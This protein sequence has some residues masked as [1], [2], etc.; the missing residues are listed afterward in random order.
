[1]TDRNETSAQSTSVD[2]RRAS[3]TVHWV[4][5]GRSTGSGLAALA[6]VADVVLWGRADD[7]IENCL[8]RNG[9]R[10][11]V[12]G[13]RYDPATLAAALVPGDVLV[14]MVPA[15]EHPELLRACLER[16]AHFAC[17]SYTSPQ[18]QALEPAAQKAGIVV[19]TEAGLDPGIDHLLAH[20]LVD[21]ARR[22]LGDTPAV[23]RLTSYCGGLPAEPNE[24][25]YRFSWAPTGVLTALLS[26]ARFVRRG[27]EETVTRPWEQ[28]QPHTVAGESFEVYPNRDSVPFVE[29]YDIPSQWRVEDFVRGTLRLNGW[30]AAWSEV[31]D[32]VGS[33]DT[34]A[35][36][37]LAGELARRHPMTSTDTDRVVLTV[38]LDVQSDDGERFTDEHVLDLTG[39]E[40]ETAMARCVS[41]TLACAVKSVLDGRCPAGIQ[42]AARGAEAVR[43]LDE[44]RGAGI[45]IPTRP[46][47]TA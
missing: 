8:R 43:W 28:T 13:R 11:R 31:F 18:M 2:V 41:R 42:R 3:G 27:R 33:G 35:I 23:A 37:A 4:G 47:I 20:E 16:G 9:V 22:T 10:D 7:R 12:P 46:T 21:R 1:M 39:D 38:A 25:R 34:D 14:S 44:L 6:D 5:T 15:V 30:R 24:F 19:L 45:S 29:V 36:A 32:V 17:T 26:P 40:R